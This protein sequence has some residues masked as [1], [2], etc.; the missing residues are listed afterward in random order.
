MNSVAS[1]A[2]YEDLWVV[3]PRTLAEICELGGSD[4]VFMFYMLPSEETADI[5]ELSQVIF[6]VQNFVICI[7]DI[8]EREMSLDYLAFRGVCTVV[9]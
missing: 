7:G 1:W 3:I 2:K 5:P 9:F 8:L 4:V 6:R